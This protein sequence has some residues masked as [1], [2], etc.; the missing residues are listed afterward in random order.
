M[1]EYHICYEVETNLCTGYNVIANSYIKALE[2]FR[3]SF[4]N[5]NII[6]VTKKK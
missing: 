2:K 6:Y 5:Q 3:K 1:K 4:K